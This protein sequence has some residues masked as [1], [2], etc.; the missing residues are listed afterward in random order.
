M[1]FRIKTQNQ[2]AAD[3][4]AISAAY[5][6]IAGKTDVITDLLPAANEAAAQNGYQGTTPAVSYPYADDFVSNGIAVTLQQTQGALLAAP[7]L[8]RVTITNKAV[9]TITLFDNPCIL[10]LGTT[11][12]DV[13]IAASTRLKMPDCGIAANSISRTAIALTDPTSSVVASAICDTHPH[14]PCHGHRRFRHH[15]AA[16]A[17]AYPMDTVGIQDT[18][19]NS[20]QFT[21]ALTFPASFPQGREG[22]DNTSVACSES[23]VALGRPGPNRMFM[24]LSASRPFVPLI[25]WPAVPTTLTA[26]TQIRLQ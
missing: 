2:S 15:G 22:D 21:P 14:T 10:T 23:C 16:Y 1:W 6:I 20:M 13:E 4:A 17:R 24:T 3:A 25:P 9:A 12:T 19:Q 11:S 26:T 5:Q 8:S 18:M 7:F